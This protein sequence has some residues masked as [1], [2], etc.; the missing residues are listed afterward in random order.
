MH[1]AFNSKMYGIH[2]RCID[3]KLYCGMHIAT[4]RFHLKDNSARPAPRGPQVAQLFFF[5]IR[6]SRGLPRP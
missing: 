2:V 6:H 4:Y 1:V 5:L 3:T